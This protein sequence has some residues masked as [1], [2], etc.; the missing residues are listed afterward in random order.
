[1]NVYT[2]ARNVGIKDPDVVHK[3]EE[4]MRLSRIKIPGGLGPVRSASRSRQ[5]Y[6]HLFHTAPELNSTV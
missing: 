2:L 5:S 4:L 6:L 3:A 1:M